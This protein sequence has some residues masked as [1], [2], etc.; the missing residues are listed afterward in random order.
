MCVHITCAW[1]CLFLGRVPYE[2][3]LGIEIW[4]V[5]QKG[6]TTFSPTCHYRLPFYLRD[7]HAAAFKRKVNMTMAF[8]DVRV[9]LIVDCLLTPLMHI[10]ALASKVINWNEI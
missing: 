6:H 7:T 5:R 1:A 10:V 3:S 2:F 8:Q 4:L 9:F